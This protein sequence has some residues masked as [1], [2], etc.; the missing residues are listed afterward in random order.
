MQ[1]KS[2]EKMVDKKSHN[3]IKKIHRVHCS[4]SVGKKTLPKLLKLKMNNNLTHK[5]N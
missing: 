2:G 1:R 4:D 3:A 5:N